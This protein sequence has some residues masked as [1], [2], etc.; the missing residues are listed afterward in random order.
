[1]QLSGSMQSTVMGLTTASTPASAEARSRPA[2]AVGLASGRGADTSFY[3]EG[4]RQEEHKEKR[5]QKSR[6]RRESKLESRMKRRASEVVQASS[7]RIAPKS[8]MAVGETSR[9]GGEISRPSS[10][11]RPSQSS[12][13]HTTASASV[14]NGVQAMS[15][16]GSS[17]QILTRDTPSGPRRYAAISRAAR[18]VHHSTRPKRLCPYAGCNNV[19]GFSGDHELRRHIVR[20]HSKRRPVWILVDISADKSVLKSCKKCQAGK[21]YNAEYNAAEHLRRHLHKNAKQ[22]AKLPLE[23]LQPW[24]RMYEEINIGDDKTILVE[25]PQKNR[26]LGGHKDDPQKHRKQEKNR[27]KTEDDEMLPNAGCGEMASRPASRSFA[28]SPSP[29]PSPSSS[30]AS[31]HSAA[32]PGDCRHVFELSSYGGDE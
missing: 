1:M 8:K 19:N 10:Q 24:M 17:T 25:I 11:G 14:E 21:R 6:S 2:T 30:P 12:T 26:A 32:S 28:P 18:A 22:Q 5:Q 27:L 20:E 15:E 9:P 3:D 7:L 29:S 23:T 31:F 16:G 4:A 13:E